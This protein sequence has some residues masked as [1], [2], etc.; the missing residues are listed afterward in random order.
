M[1]FGNNRFPVP[2]PVLH[3]PHSAQ[4]IR[5]SPSSDRAI[6]LDQPQLPSPDC[7]YGTLCVGV[8]RGAGTA[9]R[10]ARGIQLGNWTDPIQDSYKVGTLG[11]RGSIKL[12]H[13]NR[14]LF[15]E[16]MGM[17]RGGGSMVQYC[18]KQELRLGYLAVPLVLLLRTPQNAASRATAVNGRMLL[19]QETSETALPSSAI[20]VPILVSP[21]QRA[22]VRNLH[23]STV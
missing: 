6:W 18:P 16:E 21:T 9:A 22:P 19:R 12:N 23:S 8:Q 10:A 13:C 20:H 2:L 17:A 7:I 4:L 15:L 3:E 11:G 5:I 1:D 14:L